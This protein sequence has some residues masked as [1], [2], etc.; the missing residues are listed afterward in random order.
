[1]NVEKSDSFENIEKKHLRKL[2]D[3]ETLTSKVL[4]LVAKDTRFFSEPRLDLIL[5]KYPRLIVVFSHSSPL[6]WIPA[7]CLLASHLLARG[8]G[9]RT[10]ISVMDRFFYTLPGLKQLAKYITQSETPL[11]FREL[12]HHFQ[13]LETADLVVFPEGSNSFFGEPSQLQPFR[14]ARFVEIA[15]RTNTPLLLAVHRGSEDWGKALQLNRRWFDFVPAFAQGLVGRRLRERA[16][17]TVP[18][19]PKRMSLFSMCCE[20]YE[21]ETTTLADEPALRHQQI[22]DESDRIHVH[23]QAML[24]K[25]DTD[26]DASLTT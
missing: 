22:R 20:L 12:V 21:C 13:R 23:M 19:L 10:P 14:S 17:L 16:V 24:L 3:Y 25:L 8:G 9:G 11:S 5:S 1:M 18:L 7:P 15:I 2:S 26:L 4:S 6:S